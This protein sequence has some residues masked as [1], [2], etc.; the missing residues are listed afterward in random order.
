MELCL[1]MLLA[2]KHIVLTYISDRGR[3][4]NVNEDKASDFVDEKK[5]CDSF[6]LI[7]WET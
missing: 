7:L 3:R 5:S 6:A 4:K 2:H 1:I